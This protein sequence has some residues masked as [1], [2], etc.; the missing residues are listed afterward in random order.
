MEG[1][2]WNTKAAHNLF[3]LQAREETPPALVSY[4]KAIQA[5]FPRED[6]RTFSENELFSRLASIGAPLDKEQFLHLAKQTR[7]PEEL[8]Q[9]LL[10]QQKPPPL[11]SP[12]YLLIFE[13][14]RRF[15]PERRPHALFFDELD[16]Q[17]FLYYQDK[18]AKQELQQH[19]T[20]F[21]NRLTEERNKGKTAHE[22]RAFLDP[23]LAHY[24][25]HFFYDY[26]A[27]LIDA[28]SC[29][30]AERLLHVFSPYLWEGLWFDFLFLRILSAQESPQF[31]T[32]LHAL[33]EELQVHRDRELQLAL[34]E[35]MQERQDPT[36]FLFLVEKSTLLLQKEEDFLELVKV[37]QEYYCRME[38][39]ELEERLSCLLEKR[40]GY[41]LKKSFAKKD[42]DLQEF[43][44]ILGL[45]R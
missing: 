9:R 37:V 31:S 18:E 22:A 24:F 1:I 39:K 23:Y 21:L 27:D 44:D 29:D 3:L 28:D 41:S 19:I 35:F 43:I 25:D 26:L 40:K 6:F 5:F 17:I 36:S 34:L 10:L 45:F 38:K 33:I 13:L 32:K 12:T 7:N 4:M 20:S 15:L 16:R 42:P 2:S 14:W 8:T 11:F 30:D